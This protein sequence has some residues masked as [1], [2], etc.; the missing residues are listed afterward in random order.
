MKTKQ[1]KSIVFIALFAVIFSGN[2]IAQRGMGRNGNGNGQGQ[3][4]PRSEFRGEFRNH[5]IPNLSDE[6]ETKLDE[7]RVKHLKEVQGFKSKLDILGAELRALEIAEKADMKSIHA[8]IDEMGALRI[9]MQKMNAQHRQ[10]V[11]SLLTD[12]Q[13]VF[14]DAHSGRRFGKGRAQNKRNGGRFME[15]GP[16][17]GTGPRAQAGNC[18]YGK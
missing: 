14:F 16:K 13:K 1:I 4:Q 5:R 10:E 2:A 9:K 3:F 15:R 11:R 17:N 6:Q 12:E 18:T 7:L 8:K